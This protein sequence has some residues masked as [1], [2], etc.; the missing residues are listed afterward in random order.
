MTD[1]ATDYMKAEFDGGCFGPRRWF[2]A[3]LGSFQ[4]TSKADAEE[5]IKLAQAASRAETNRV[6]SVMRDQLD[7]L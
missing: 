3:G 7:E 5:A 2:V 1:R 4:F 6:C